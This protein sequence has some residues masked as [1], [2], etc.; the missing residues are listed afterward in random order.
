VHH[1]AAGLIDRF[2]EAGQ[3]LAREGCAAIATTCGFLALHQ[4]RLAE[5]IPV[6]VATSALLQLPQIVSMLPKGRIVG[7]ITASE[8]SLTP[9]H[10]AAVGADPAT[11]IIGV[12]EG[13]AF[14]SAFVGNSTGLDV[15][16]ARAEVVTAAL[17]LRER[18]PNLGAIL[19]ECANM[20]PYAIDVQ[21]ATGFPVFD[22]VGLIC[23]LHQ[24]LSPPRYPEG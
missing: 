7:V 10:L 21:R 5:A 9:A 24:A 19:L 18:H 1:N 12:P 13:G 14:S 16:G 17:G 2:I 20:G 4:Q 22:M 23:S 15:P 3:I 11:P 6:P 8:R